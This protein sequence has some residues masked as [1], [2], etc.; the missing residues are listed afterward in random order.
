[1]LICSKYRG[2]YGKVSLVYAETDRVCDDLRFGFGDHVNKSMLFIYF[3]PDII[4][5]NDK[6]TSYRYVRY[7]VEYH[8][9]ASVE[10]RGTIL[11]YFKNS[12]TSLQAVQFLSRRPDKQKQVVCR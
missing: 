9:V 8:N 12:L 6:I 2:C 10:F 7:I 5:F 3:S 1:M 11:Y 4:T